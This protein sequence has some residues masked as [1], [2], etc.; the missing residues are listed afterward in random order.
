MTTQ[1]ELPVTA[2]GARTRGPSLLAR[3]PEILPVATAV[4][5]W[6]A[7]V[8]WPSA[9]SAPAV[10]AA[11]GAAPGA[12]RGSVTVPAGHHE[13]LAAIGAGT[14]VLPS[15]LATSVM[16]LAMM[17]PLAIP[18]VRAVAAGSR[19]W[20]AG[21][22][23]L[24]FFLAFSVGWILATI[25]LAVIGGV[26]TGWLGAQAAAVLLLVACAAVL[27]VPGRRL[28]THDRI[29]RL[30][31]RGWS[32]DA[33]CARAGLVSA[34]RGLPLCGPPMLAMLVVPGGLVTMAAI[35]GLTLLDRITEGRRP[36]LVA[37]GYAATA[38][39]ILLFRG[40]QG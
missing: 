9:S 15:L 14:T 18:G 39:A 34:V 16:A 28:V 35:S 38:A 40:G 26:L 36:L 5:A 27:F 6:A 13:T 24:W 20:R 19:W 22:A 23:A 8:G 3:R 12:V 4:A 29:G 25:P 7:L 17:S 10:S 32:A 30:R 11:S 37:G 1:R 2:A 21:R 31:D 33:D